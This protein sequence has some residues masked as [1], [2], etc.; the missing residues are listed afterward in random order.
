MV[1]V[2][3]SVSRRRFDLQLE[4]NK[5]DDSDVLQPSN[6]EKTSDLKVK[7]SI[8]SKS[9]ESK[10]P[11]LPPKKSKD[12]DNV[13]VN[14]NVTTTTA[15]STNPF[16]DFD[17]L[18]GFAGAPPSQQPQQQQLDFDLL[19]DQTTT[20]TTT[21]VA[22]YD[23]NNDN[24]DDDDT[25]QQPLQQVATTLDACLDRIAR[26]RAAQFDVVRLLAEQ[27]DNND[28]V[29]TARQILTDAVFFLP[30]WHTLSKPVRS[31]VCE[32]VIVLCCCCC[33]CC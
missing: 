11:P 16:Q 23:N 8:E 9:S 12:K 17:A 2:E 31:V 27:F 1:S 29:T 18:G 14:V 26:L 22:L 6:V 3:I 20:T 28:A 33:C 4:Q 7:S 32:F 19:V 21:N 25:T 24:D 13:N 10:A 15:Q 30:M 5:I